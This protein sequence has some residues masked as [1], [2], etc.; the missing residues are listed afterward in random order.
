[1]VG[2]VCT[3]TVDVRSVYCNMLLNPTPK[4]GKAWLPQQ[5]RLVAAHAQHH[6]RQS[7]PWWQ[8]DNV[9]TAVTCLLAASASVWQTMQ[10]PLY[11]LPARMDRWSEE[12]RQ[13]RRLEAQMTQQ[14]QALEPQQRSAYAGFCLISCMSSTDGG[15]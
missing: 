10:T 3:A 6:K 14:V 7:E 2:S 13:Q 8:Q 11:Q 12:F 4:V 15:H 9:H 5:R 1:M